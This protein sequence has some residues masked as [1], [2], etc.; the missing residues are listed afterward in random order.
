VSTRK[1]VLSALRTAGEAGVGGEALAARLGVSRVAISK[2]VSAL[3]E[4]GYSIDAAP[5]SGYR[6]LSAPDLPLPGEVEPLL[7]TRMWTALTGGAETG[8]TN[9]DARALARA[10]APE[11]SVVLA[12]RQTA[13]R[14]R[15][16][17][18]WTSPG[19]GVYLSAVLRP[20]V[21]PVEVASLAL[22]VALGVVCGLES[23]GA[24]PR[25]KWPNDVLSG[26]GKLVGVLLEM[27]A[28]SDAV[29]WVIAGVGLNV[30]PPS[31][32]SRT[33]GAAYLADDLGDVG[34]ARA[35]AAMLDGIAETYA[36][37]RDGGFSA[38]RGQYEAR[39]ALA[40]QHV[41]VSDLTGVVRAQGKVTGV[42]DD[43]RLLVRS[44]DGRVQAVV[45]GEVTLRE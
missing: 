9:D 35:A 5:S 12:A 34:L 3:R 30:R 11:G 45:A 24:K 13:G 25:L 31:D 2:H 32:E 20:A 43:G 41:R 36:Q 10:G 44:A 39:F 17:R 37:W 27:S 18:S 16:G 26:E 38:I 6:L 21:A 28:E 7:R 29:D 15:L 8:S 1:D 4:A 40:G 42:D 14:G 19:G 22:A 23:L 33:P